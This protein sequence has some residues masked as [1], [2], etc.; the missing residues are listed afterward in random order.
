MTFDGEKDMR[1]SDELSFQRFEHRPL[2]PEQ[3]DTIKRYAMWRAQA[4]RGEALR[5]VVRGIAAG[6]RAAAH[7]GGTL[8]AKWANGFARWREQR[9][10]VREHSGLDDRMLK[11][12]G[13]HRSEI[14]SVV[15]GRECGRLGEGKVAARLL[16][17][18][19]TPPPARRATRPAQKIN[20]A[21]A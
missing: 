9:A 3:L 11:D 7:G 8:A 15:Y 1:E 6:W 19:Y 10:A 20:K 13:L 18:P 4:E 2:S 12:L 21:A 14:E 16:H 17:K 5:R